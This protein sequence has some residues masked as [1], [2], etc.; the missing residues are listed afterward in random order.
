M[1]R[2]QISGDRTLNYFAW[3]VSNF[4]PKP[5]VLNY[6][7][8]GFPQSEWGS[9]I[10]GDATWNGTPNFLNHWFTVAGYPGNAQS[11]Y[12]AMRS[13]GGSWTWAATDFVVQKGGIL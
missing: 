12:W 5:P 10:W 2:P 3:M 13:E 6:N 1:V 7:T 4:E 11:L 8:D 9:A